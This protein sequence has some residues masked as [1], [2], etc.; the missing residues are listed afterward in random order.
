MYKGIKKTAC[1]KIRNI[2]YTDHV[3]HYRVPNDELSKKMF[4]IDS[5]FYFPYLKHLSCASQRQKKGSRGNDL[6]I[7]ELNRKRRKIEADKVESKLEIKKTY[8]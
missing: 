2:R 6:T 7:H 1:N 8:S 3:L 5:S 4:L